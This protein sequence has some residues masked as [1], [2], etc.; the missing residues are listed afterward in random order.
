MP[1]VRLQDYASQVIPVGSGAVEA[2]NWA[3]NPW[4]EADHLLQARPAS[5]DSQYQSGGIWQLGVSTQTSLVADGG[6]LP[7]DEF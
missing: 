3:S 4:M 7:L 1:G 6:P 5:Y 2:K